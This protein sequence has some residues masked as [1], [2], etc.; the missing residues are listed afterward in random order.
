M[1]SCQG[2]LLHIT[3]MDA[4]G[5]LVFPLSCD[6]V[7]PVRWMFVQRAAGHHHSNCLPL[8]VLADTEQ[9]TAFITAYSP[10]RAVA[11]R[12]MMLDTSAFP[13]KQV[14]LFSFISCK[15]GLLLMI[16]YSL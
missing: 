7:G 10:G 6:N 11:V 8:S 3:Q 15:N 13:Q 4:S 2:K 1:L 16:R 14:F 12:L 5:Q 9:L